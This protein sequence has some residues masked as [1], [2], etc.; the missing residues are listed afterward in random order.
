MLRPPHPAWFNH[1]LR[2]SS[3]CYFLHDPSSSLLGPNILNTLFSKTSSLCSSLKMRGQVSHPYSTTGKLQF[4]FL[5]IH[6]NIIFPY[7][8]R[9]SSGLPFRLSDQNVVRTR[10]T[11]P[12]HFIL[13]D[14]ISLKIFYDAYKLWSLSRG[15]HHS[16]IFA[17]KISD[18][19][20]WIWHA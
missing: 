17:Q 15:R 11:R 8:P 5:Q 9:S 13:L 10:A 19:C 3:L 4:C 1:R 16:V 20:A 14:L 2:S 18:A 12:A 6:Y 7:T